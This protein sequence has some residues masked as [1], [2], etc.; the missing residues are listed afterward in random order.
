[1]STISKPVAFIIGYGSNLGPAIAR[2]FRSEGF[3]VAVS[4]RTLDE[5]AAKEDG[6][7]SIQADFGDIASV[8]NAFDRLESELGPAAAV[9]YN[10]YS[11]NNTSPSDPLANSYETFLNNVNVTGVNVYEVARRTKAGFE[12]LPAETPR[13][14]IGTGNLTPWVHFH[15]LL[16][17]SVG[18]RAMA[19]IVEASA[20]AYGPQGYRFYFAHEVKGSTGGPQPQPTGQAH[21]DVFYRIWQQ[22][23]Q[24]P[25]E[26]CFTETGALYDR[27]AGKVVA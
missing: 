17:L 15:T 14:F 12:K 21:A 2:K 8:R 18:K 23:E 5:K 10:A 6:Y 3:N 1:M 9:V 11:S 26:V 13:A 20:R 16:G 24:G 27:A 25:W 4:A 7:L 19:N 22:K